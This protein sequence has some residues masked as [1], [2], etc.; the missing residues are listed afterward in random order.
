MIMRMKWV[1]V[2][3]RHMLH[4]KYPVNEYIMYLHFFDV[5][6]GEFGSPILFL[7]DVSM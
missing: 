2:L 5:D 3:S 4:S 7:K 1:K 6:E